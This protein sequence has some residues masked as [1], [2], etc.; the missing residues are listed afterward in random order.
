LSESVATC[1]Y[2]VANPIMVQGW[3]ALT[4]LHWRF[5]PNLVQRLLPAGLDVE[6]RDGDAWVG[7]VPFLMDVGL[8]HMR[9]VPWASRFCETNVRTY[10]RDGAGRSGIWFFSLD[11]ARLAAVAVARATYRLPYYW[12]S[13]RVEREGTI[14]RYRCRRRVPGPRGATSHATIE[15]GDAYRTDELGALDHFLTARW[16]LFS[17]AGDRRR[18]AIA[19]HPPWPLHRATVMDL[20]DEL[21]A[22]AGLPPVEGPPIAHYSPGVQVKIGRPQAETM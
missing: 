20:H 11:A 12:A 14:I 7:L 22:A 3:T 5:P 6:T 9:S 19:E 13:M 21:L 4:F 8:P 1:P 10:V 18:F 2:R 15:I 17:V 16:A